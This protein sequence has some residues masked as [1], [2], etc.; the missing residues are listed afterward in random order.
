MPVVWTAQGPYV[1]EVT[2]SYGPYVNHTFRVFNGL[3]NPLIGDLL[4]SQTHIGPLPNFQRHSVGVLYTT[5][6]KS[7]GVL[8]QYDQGTQPQKR[9]IDHTMPVQGNT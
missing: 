2:L 7:G 4:E 8:T 6:V 5:D 3:G 1:W 9:V